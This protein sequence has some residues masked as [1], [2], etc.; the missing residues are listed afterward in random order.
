MG[1]CENQAEGAMKQSMRQKRN[2]EMRMRRFTR[3]KDQGRC[4]GRQ[5]KGGHNGKD[6]NDKRLKGVQERDREQGGSGTAEKA[7]IIQLGE[8]IGLCLTTVW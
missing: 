5:R 3:C 8:T 6:E 7:G 4:W 1:K 2:E